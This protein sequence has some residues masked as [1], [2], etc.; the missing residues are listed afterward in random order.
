MKRQTVKHLGALS[1]IDEQQRY[2]QALFLRGDGAAGHVAQ[3]QVTGTVRAGIA[4]GVAGGPQEHTPRQPAS[5]LRPQQRR[6]VLPAVFKGHVE[7]ARAF[8]VQLAAEVHGQGLLLLDVRHGTHEFFPHAG[9]AHAAAG[10][11]TGDEPFR[12]LAQIAVQAVHLTGRAGKQHLPALIQI[13]PY[14]LI[15]LANVALHRLAPPQLGQIVQV[16][17]GDVADPQA[18]VQ[19]RA[20]HHAAALQHVFR[21]GGERAAGGG[22]TPHGLVAVPDD[23]RCRLGARLPLLQHRADMRA[24]AALD[25][26]I[27]H[28]RVQKALPVRHHA[29][30]ALGTA[31]AARGAAGA[32]LPRGQL[33]R[34]IH[35]GHGG[36]LLARFLPH[37]V[38]H[39][40]K[41]H[42]CAEE[43]SVFSDSK[44]G[45]MGTVKGRTL[46][47]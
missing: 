34:G 17:H 33:R 40:D 28:L 7:T 15:A 41:K 47:S 39:A 6:V 43:L 20:E 10:H 4:A 42:K 26:A 46:N 25:T 35:L 36:H 14:L 2:A 37:I 44:L 45:K 1:G 3:R 9:A 13:Q 8:T 12:V 32:S 24:V 16:F 18:A 38:P 27:G 11:V 22:V 29:D 19:C 30:S 23:K 21:Q 31:I 5:H